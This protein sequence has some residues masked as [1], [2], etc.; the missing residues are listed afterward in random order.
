V[1][2]SAGLGVNEAKVMSALH[3][4]Q[5]FCSSHGQ[6][7]PLLP[8][9]PPRLHRSE[10]ELIDRYNTRRLQYLCLE[11]KQ[12]YERHCDFHSTYNIFNA[13]ASAV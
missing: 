7:Q 5:W 9:N 2:K 3:M 12:Y 1:G 4:A 11:Q 6:R 8:R 10:A 13:I